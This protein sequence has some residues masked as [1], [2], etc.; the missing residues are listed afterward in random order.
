VD[1]TTDEAKFKTFINSDAETMNREIRPCLNFE[2]LPLL[3]DPYSLD[4]DHMEKYAT[5]SEKVP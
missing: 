5:G 1:I 3:S 2:V 4:A